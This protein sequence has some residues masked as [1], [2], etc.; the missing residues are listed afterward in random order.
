MFQQ[1]TSPPEI[2]P[3]VYGPQPPKR[4]AAG[5]PGLTSVGIEELFSEMPVAIYRQGDDPSVVRTATVEALDELDMTRIKAGDK[6][7]ILC[8]EHGFL[9]MGGQAYAEM[10]KT[11]KDVVEEKTGCPNIRLRFAAGIGQK[12]AEEVFE[13]YGLDDYF[14][15][16]VAG[17]TPFGRGV[18]IETDI[19]TLYGLARLYDSDWFIHVHYDDLREV[20]WHRLIDRGLKPFVMSYARLETRAVYHFNF[21]PRSSNFLQRAMFNAPFIQD[22][23]AFS[24]FIMTA[25]SGVTGVRAARDIDQ[26][27]REIVSTGLRYYARMV[28]VLAE[29]D[30]CVAVLDAGRWPH[31]QHAGGVTFGNLV[32]AQ[33][34]Y[35]DL[36]TIPAATGFA[37]FERPP[38]APKI[39]T[40]NP[41]IKALVI[42]HMWTGMMCTELPLSL[43][44]VVVGRELADKLRLDSANPDF[45][46]AAVTAESL[47]AAVN[48]ALRVAGTDKVLVFDGCFGSMNLS[49]G[50]K[51]F[52]MQ[53]APRVSQQIEQELLP[54][55]L[56]QRNLPLGN[57]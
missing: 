15:G 10:I 8:S 54:K 30:Q 32:N 40:V 20:Y 4:R 29:M 1:P 36:D 57:D 21:G 17:V 2:M 7:N 55:W 56:G 50:L 52:L 39:K 6:V 33:L 43:P 26:I 41:A 28:K 16:R 53:K 48:F 3:S 42:N 11:I 35:F 51:E 27:D 38:Q 44:T 25:P 12:E 22:R 5:L 45:M 34:D 18:P 19:G 23:Y 13:F 31:Y 46:N 37:L 49:P 9:I 24:V 47:E 14:D